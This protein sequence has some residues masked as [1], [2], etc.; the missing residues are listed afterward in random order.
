MCF[1]S[2]TESEISSEISFFCTETSY[3]QRIYHKNDFRNS[4]EGKKTLFAHWYGILFP[5]RSIILQLLVVKPHFI[6]IYFPMQPGKL[7]TFRWI[8][9]FLKCFQCSESRSK[10]FLE[11]KC[12][13]LGWFWYR[14]RRRYTW[15]KVYQKLILYSWRLLWNTGSND[16]FGYFIRQ[17]KNALAKG[18]KSQSLLFLN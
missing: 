18:R 2:I 3:C 6:R 13:V 16:L 4:V 5:S 8:P 9:N 17:W 10:Q 1:Q 12:T 14:K 15:N 11:I 7:I